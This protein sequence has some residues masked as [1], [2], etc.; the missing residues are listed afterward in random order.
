MARRPIVL[1]SL[2]AVLVAM[3]SPARAN[4]PN[5]FTDHSVNLFC[6]DPL[7]DDAGVARLFFAGVSSEFGAFGE[8]AFWAGQTEPVGEPDLVTDFE[9]P[10]TGSTSDSALTVTIPLIDPGTGF[11]SGEAIVEATLAPVGDPIPI[12]FR[13]RFGN[14]QSRGSGTIQ[15]MTVVSGTLTIGGGTFSLEGCAGEVVD[16]MVFE[17]RPNSSVFDFEETFVFCDLSTEDNEVFLFAVASEDF[18]FAELSISDP[19]LFGFSDDVT[20]TLDTFSATLFVFNDIT[21]EQVDDAVIDATVTPEP[22]LEVRLRSQFGMLKGTAQPLSIEGTLDVPAIGQTFD[23]SS[24]FGQSIDYHVVFTN[25]QG[26]PPSEKVPVNDTPDGAIALSPSVHVTTQTRGA[27][28]EGE[29]PASC[30]MFDDVQVNIARTLWYTVAGTGGPITIDT[31]GSDFDTVLV[32]YTRK[33]NTFTEV[34]CVDDIIVDGIQFSL[35]SALTVDTRAG[36]TYYVQAGGFATEY[37][38]LKLSVS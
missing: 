26:P 31:A 27:S 16:V 22:L 6:A 33:R 34:G 19:P 18:S 11:P 7:V 12:E 9:T 30:L 5:R 3:A 25:P 17:T 37:G 24:C 28:P 14:Q 8:V 4:A 29:Q 35:Q 21:G 15:P 1:V 13:D 20:L 32:V 23:L 36:V 10:A 38:T 2:F